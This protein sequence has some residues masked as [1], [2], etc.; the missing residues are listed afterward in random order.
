MR[1]TTC[2]S[3]SVGGVV[4]LA[5]ATAVTLLTRMSAINA[6]ANY[7]AVFASWLRDYAIAQ[8][9]IGLILRDLSRCAPSRMPV[10][11]VTPVAGVLAGIAEGGLRYA[12]SEPPQRDI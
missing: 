5:A 1:A 12:F 4:K 7:M 2:S 6:S 11:G 9:S 3:G 10:V 8:L